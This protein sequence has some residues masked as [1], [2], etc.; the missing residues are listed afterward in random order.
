[1]RV[2]GLDIGTRRV[3]VAL[4]DD[5]GMTAQPLET[6]HV[7]AGESALPRIVA[8]CEEHGVSRV[9]AGVPF[10]FDGREGR[11]ARL[12]RKVLAKVGEET[13]LEV[14]EVDERLTSRQAER[15]L[16]EADVSRARRKQV[17]DKMAAA[18][19]LQGWLDSQADQRR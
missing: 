9:V 19:I 5:L 6:I 15:A 13:G 2:L 18:L 12:V 14:D 4:S 10:E 17:I 8:L 7:R 11:M 3:G 16:L 1:M